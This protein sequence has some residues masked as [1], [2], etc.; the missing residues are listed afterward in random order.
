MNKTTKQ[1]LVILTTILT[2]SSCNDCIND[3][4]PANARFLF[5]VQDTEGNPF[6]EE[7]EYD[8]PFES[9]EIQI[10][11]FNNKGDEQEFELRQDGLTLRFNLS[12]SFNRYLINYKSAKD[13]TLNFNT[14][15]YNDDCCSNIPA[16]YH[17][18]VNSNG[19][20]VSSLLDSTFIFI[21]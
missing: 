12:T 19:S 16:K 9:D 4:C 11:G 1:L 13:D 17:V 7:T 8:Q 5:E 3:D 21:K 20:L 10:I 18:G 14:E 2:L 15:V 6:F